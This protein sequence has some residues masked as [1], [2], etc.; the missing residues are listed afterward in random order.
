M[1]LLL[2]VQPAIAGR[3]DVFKLPKGQLEIFPVGRWQA[4]SED[5]GELKIV[6]AAEDP[7]INARA[8]YSVASEGSDDFP[9]EQQLL[10]HMHRVATRLLDGGTF[11]ERKPVVKPFYPAQGFGFY[12]VMTD[13]K[14]VGRPPVPGDFKFFSLGMIRLAPAVYL[15]VQ[16][17]ADSEEGEPYQQLLGMAEGV[18][19]TPR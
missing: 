5:V 8:I 14:L 3:A 17:M 7:Q 9:T 19:Y 13:R 12:A 1:I 2:L 18:T 15:K 10:E 16:I 11:V 6:L 4:S